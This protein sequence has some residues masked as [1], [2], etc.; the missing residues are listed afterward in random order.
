MKLCEAYSYYFYAFCIG[1]AIFSFWC[2]YCDI[3]GEGQS[4]VQTKSWSH[5][6][7]AG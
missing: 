4:K 3:K 6:C 1:A 7:A 5:C 2:A